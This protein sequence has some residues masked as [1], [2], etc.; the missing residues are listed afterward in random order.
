MA[1]NILNPH[2]NL[3]HMHGYHHTHTIASHLAGPRLEM[4]LLLHSSAAP[5]A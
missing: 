5:H 1:I 4:I 2:Y 3:P